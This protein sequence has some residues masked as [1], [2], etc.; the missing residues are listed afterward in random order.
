MHLPCLERLIPAHEMSSRTGQT[1]RDNAKQFI[2]ECIAAG[3]V[4][5]YHTNASRA[6]DSIQECIRLGFPIPTQVIE[7]FGGY[8][9]RKQIRSLINSGARVNVIHLNPQVLLSLCKKL[10]KNS[11][12]R[13]EFEKHIKDVIN[14]ARDTERRQISMDFH[15][16]EQYDRR[17][18][19]DEQYCIQAELYNTQDQFETKSNES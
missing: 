16:A 2:L 18:F 1:K 11:A 7:F 19:V 9:T 14:K 6:F 12:I 15:E 10:P 8:A 13:A 17:R 3:I 5:K 4:Y